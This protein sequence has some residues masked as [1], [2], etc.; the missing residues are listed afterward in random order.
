[1]ECLSQDF[2]SWD[3]DWLL[4]RHILHGLF[5]KWRGLSERTHNLYT[6]LATLFQLARV[7]TARVQ[8]A[9]VFKSKVL[10]SGA[11]ESAILVTRV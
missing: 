11:A 10:I 3:W 1:M 2:G 8:A 5:R 7:V 9:V 4:A 6:K